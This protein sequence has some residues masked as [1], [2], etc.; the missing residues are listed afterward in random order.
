MLE[1]EGSSR[2]GSIWMNGHETMKQRAVNDMSETVEK[3]LEIVESELADLKKRVADN[4]AAGARK[5][6]WRRT[7]GMSSNDPEFEEIVRLGQ[8]YRKA[9]RWEDEPDAGVGH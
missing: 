4:E 8:E 1:V 9:Q 6:D 7:F 3:R 5:K 2:T